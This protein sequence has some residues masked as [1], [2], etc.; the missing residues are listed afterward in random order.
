MKMECSTK[1]RERNEL[2]K[3]EA[4]PLKMTT[5]VMGGLVGAIAMSFW[6]NRSMNSKMQGSAQ[7]AQSSIKNIIRGNHDIQEE[8]NKIATEN[9]F[10]TV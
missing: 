4:K 3:K 5:F 2:L 9:E 6:S 10:P 1:N 7:R 8:V